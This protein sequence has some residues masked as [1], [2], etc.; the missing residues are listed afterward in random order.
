MRRFIALTAVAMLVG[1]A[2]FAA[3]AH[4]L[5]LNP[6]LCNGSNLGSCPDGSWPYTIATITGS[7]TVTMTLDL[8]NLQSFQSVTE[9]WFN[10]NPALDGATLTLTP[11]SGDTGAIKAIVSA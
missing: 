6:N 5:T 9:W 11:V 3:S 8:T 2:S 10:L 7:G 1:V 4:A